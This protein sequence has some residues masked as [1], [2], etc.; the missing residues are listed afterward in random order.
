MKKTKNEA[1]LGNDI[2]NA[3][4]KQKNKTAENKKAPSEKKRDSEYRELPFKKVLYGYDPEEVASYIDELNENHEASSRIHESKLSSLKEELVLSNRERDSYGEKYRECKA[5]LNAA[6]KKAAEP[7]REEK[8]DKSAEYEAVI[9]QLKEKIEQIQF[10]NVQLKE[11]ISE[12]SK[13]KDYGEY[14][15]RIAALEN[16]NRQI[17][18]RA[19]ALEREKTELV[20]SVQKYDSLFG[21]YNAVLAKLEQSKAEIASKD[22]E[23]QLIREELERKIKELNAVSC[24]NEENKKKAAELEVK[25]GVLSQRIEENEESMLRLRDAN[26]TQAFEYADKIN[27]LE[28]EL[29]RRKL[30]MQKELKLQDYYINQAELTLAE[31]TKQMEQIRQS[32]SDVQS[33]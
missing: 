30:E 32:M 15:G 23:N 26:K 25:N 14:L 21:D 19:N 10:E 17:G 9:A 22:S 1:A 12:Q 24:E 6:A 29:A 20:A 33:V 13:E 4:N 18:I 8:E 5:E 11:Q 3:E 31:L 16:E 7:Q 2:K 28:N 27:S